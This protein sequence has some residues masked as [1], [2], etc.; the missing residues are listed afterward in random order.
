MYD[1]KYSLY[2]YIKQQYMCAYTT[3]KYHYMY[4]NSLCHIC[5]YIQR[6]YTCIYVTYAYNCP[7]Y[8]YNNPVYVYSY[9]YTTTMVHVITHTP[10]LTY[11][12]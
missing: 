12:I 9:V 1:T 8:V 11:A 4:N 10:Y 6:K 5:I 3:K 7:T 2:M